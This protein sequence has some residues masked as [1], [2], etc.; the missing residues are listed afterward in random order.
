M[1]LV[2]ASTCS[3]TQKD[4]HYKGCENKQK[5]LLGRLTGCQMMLHT[6]GHG[7]ETIMG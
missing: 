7:K 4:R 5:A 1:G 2:K 3:M 6:D